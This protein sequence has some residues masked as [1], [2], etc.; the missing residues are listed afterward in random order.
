MLGRLQ[1]W[2]G[3]P[4][5]STVTI[6]GVRFPAD[7]SKP[8][9][10]PLTTTTD[11]VKDNG[12]APWGH[13]PDMRDFWKTPQGWQWRDFETFRL[14]NQPLS[15]CNGLYVL[16]YSFDSESLPIHSN[17][18]EA[19]FERQRTFAGDTFVVKLQGN[20]IGE[21]LGEDGWAVWADVP[22]DILSLPVMKM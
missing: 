12:D 4:P 19:I 15:S 16:F 8:H 7:G 18:P 20:E 22:S 21:D 3:Q 17:F 1:S 13:I 9:T 5:P 6:T 14:Q 10:L 11:G 2:L